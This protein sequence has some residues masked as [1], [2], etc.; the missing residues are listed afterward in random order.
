MNVD[1]VLHMVDEFGRAMHDDGKNLG[2]ITAWALNQQRDRL[3]EAIRKLAAG[4]T[5]QEDRASQ[6]AE[7]VIAEAAR[8]IKPAPVTGKLTTDRNDPRLTH[9]SDDAP[10]PQADAYLV[11]SEQER[12]KGFVRPYRDA[13]KHDTCG[14]VTTMGRALS[15]T[16]ARDPKFY[17]ATYCCKCQMHKPVGE[18][19]WYEMDGSIGPVVGS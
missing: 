10:V 15:E 6:A 2:S 13:Y 4:Q 7:A 3:H 8:P 1:Q 16:Y 11:L 18:F 5:P 14:T 9:G 12:A 17:G 19:R